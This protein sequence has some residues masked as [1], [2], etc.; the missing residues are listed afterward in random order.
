MTQSR[1]KEK[2]WPNDKSKTRLF[3][4][5]DILNIRH[6]QDE[7]P[8][9]KE[10]S[11]QRQEKPK[12]EKM[13]KLKKCAESKNKIIKTATLSDINTFHEHSRPTT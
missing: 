10:Q 5:S 9:L 13:G 2:L 12:L 7:G 4:N 1:I 8:Y 6:P 3:K 11:R